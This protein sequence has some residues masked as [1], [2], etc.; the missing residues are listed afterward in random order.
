MHIKKCE[1]CN[2]AFKTRKPQ[3]RFC[4]RECFAAWERAQAGYCAT[5][6]KQV[7]KGVR[8]CSKKCE[9]QDRERVVNPANRDIAILAEVARAK[10]L[11]KYGVSPHRA[12]NIYLW[13][14]VLD[15]T[16]EEML[17]LKGVKQWESKK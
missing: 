15:E 12:K 10:F 13:L 9:K 16:W 7:Q 17:S 1:W 2:R 11:R 14:D 6:G 8:Y 5:C 3:R 4:N